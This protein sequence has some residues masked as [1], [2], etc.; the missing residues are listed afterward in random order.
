[1]ILMGTTIAGCLA[2]A[3][4]AAAVAAFD[5]A[6]VDAPV[7]GGAS[8]CLP[9]QSCPLSLPPSSHHESAFAM[10]SCDIRPSILSE[11]LFLQ[12]VMKFK[13]PAAILLLG[14]CVVPILYGLSERY[15]WLPAEHHFVPNANVPVAAQGPARS[16]QPQF[17]QELLT[18]IPGTLATRVPETAATTAGISP[19]VD[20]T[21]GTPE[22]GQSARP[23]VASTLQSTMTPPPSN[24]VGISQHASP[25]SRPVQDAGA[26]GGAAHAVRAVAGAVHDGAAAHDV[27]A[28]VH[29]VPDATAESLTLANQSGHQ[30]AGLL[31]KNEGALNQTLVPVSPVVSDTSPVNSSG[32]DKTSPS[33]LVH[34]TAGAAASPVV[35]P[36]SPLAAPA[37]GPA[38]SAVVQSPLLQPTLQD[39]TG[40]SLRTSAAGASPAMHSP[41]VVPAAQQQPTPSDLATGSPVP[42]SP[43]SLTGTLYTWYFGNLQPH[44]TNW[45]P[46]A[47]FINWAQA[48][49]P[50]VQWMWCP[51]PPRTVETCG[52]PPKTEKAQDGTVYT[53]CPNDKLQAAK[54]AELAVQH[55][56]PV[57]LV[58][59]GRAKRGAPP[60]GQAEFGVLK[61][62]K[63]LNYTRL[64]VFLTTDEL[65]TFHSSKVD[66]AEVIFTQYYH[67]HLEHVN[68]DKIFYLP[69]GLHHVPL[70]H[71][72]VITVDL[73][74]SP[75]VRCACGCLWRILKATSGKTPSETKDRPPSA[76]LVPF[77]PGRTH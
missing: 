39:H 2:A 48:N 10:L 23:S 17:S 74:P 11:A 64:R 63:Q 22:T 26:D 8:C 56:V 53:F 57:L 44:H 49:H 20:A 30:S 60:A 52:R 70:S 31:L 77:E 4:V 73:W 38:V 27:T 6:P 7:D 65:C 68:S 71:L 45:A 43:G 3:V 50:K 33:A 41:A 35:A 15:D 67:H 16:P 9:T 72:P 46:V 66:A 54:C 62:F 21:D 28:A 1:M 34:M 24:D 75:F 47:N 59:K 58:V 76:G 12:N 14:L 18:P 55:K 61:H 40:S 69:T 32:P 42:P 29:D 51:N 37:D 36:A 13:K 19:P 5:I 25:S